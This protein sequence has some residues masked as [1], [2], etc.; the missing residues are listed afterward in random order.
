MLSLRPWVV[1]ALLLLT[2]AAGS[3]GA[4]QGTSLD[5]RTAPPEPAPPARPLADY[6]GHCHSD[7]LLTD[8]ILR[9]SGA[10]LLVEIGPLTRDAGRFTAPGARVAGAQLR[11]LETD[12]R[13]S[14][15]SLTSRG[16]R[17]FRLTRMAP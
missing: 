14:G 3:L 12:G 10:S 17:D 1:P 9:A 16:A 8:W 4:Q 2:S 5:A 13:V 11:F 7:E 6:A 15:L